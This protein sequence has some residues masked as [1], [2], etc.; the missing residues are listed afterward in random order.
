MKNEIITTM[1]V[2]KHKVRVI[3][4]NEKEYISLTDL[5]KYVNPEDPSGL[6]KQWMSNK[7]SFYFY[8]LWEVINNPSFNSV[9]FHRIKNNEVGRNRFLMNPTKWKKMT[10]SI[11][12]IPSSGR[13]SKGSFAHSDI[14]FEFASWLSPEFKLY[15]IT[16]FQRLKKKENYENKMDWHASRILAKVGYLIHTDSIKS[17]IVP[18]LTEQQKLFVYQEEADLIN[19]S[20]FGMTAKEWREANPNLKGNIRDYTD[21]LHLVILNNLENINSELIELGI[22]QRERLIKLNG[23]AKKQINILNNNKSL[24]NLKYIENDNTE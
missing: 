9:E 6:I 23:I 5:A 11:G 10:S 22:S 13:Y 15:L 1:N 20:L 24:D 2:N 16:E 12:I 18:N 14:A 19:V 7:D 8:G 4:I 21:L 3:K 17:N